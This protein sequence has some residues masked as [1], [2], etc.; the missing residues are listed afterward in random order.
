MLDAAY[1]SGIRYIDAARWYG[2]AENFLS[3]WLKTRNPP[4]TR[5][6]SDPSGATATWDR[7]NSMR[8][9]MK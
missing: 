2:M 1:A 9:S 4:R 7:G 5:S 3:T 6:L 8:P